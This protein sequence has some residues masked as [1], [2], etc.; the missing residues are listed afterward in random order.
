[1]R[2]PH[3]NARGEVAE[4]EEVVEP[5]RGGESLG[6]AFHR[7]RDVA[8]RD[9]PSHRLVHPPGHDVSVLVHALARDPLPLGVAERVQ[10]PAGVPQR[11]VNHA[12]RR[13]ERRAL[14]PVRVTVRGLARLA[15]VADVAAPSAPPPP[16]IFAPGAAALV[17]LHVLN[18]D[19]HALP[20]DAVGVEDADL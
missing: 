4:D 6:A 11:I 16:G 15:A 3:G 5:R 8:A 13:G 17:H 7:R 20:L 9:V 12:Q 14:R 2:R 18:L 1:M 19:A 10:G